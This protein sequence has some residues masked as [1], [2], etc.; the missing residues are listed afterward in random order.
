MRIALTADQVNQL[1]SEGWVEVFK[2]V[3]RLRGSWY[4]EVHCVGEEDIPRCPY[5]VVGQRLW[6]QEPFEVDGKKRRAI[7]MP[8]RKASISVIVVEIHVVNIP[9][10]RAKGKQSWK[11]GLRR[12]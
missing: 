5:G 12:I 11:I 2:P 6:V 4:R 10:Q 1:R 7:Q 3:I 8:R 9:W